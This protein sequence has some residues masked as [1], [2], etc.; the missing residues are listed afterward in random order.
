MSCGITDPLSCVGKLAA[1][2]ATSA[3][4]AVCASFATAADALLKAF[5]RSF[6]A[7]PPVD[8]ASPAVKSV[9][10]ICL[11]IAAGVAAVL[12]LGQVIRTAISRD[13]SPLAEGL[14]GIGKAAIACML[15]LVIT[16]AAVTAAD[17]LTSYIIDRSFGSAAGLTAHLTTVLSFIG[18][19]GHSNAELLGGASLL[20]L[21]ALAG[22]ALVLV[23]WFELL[24]RNAAIAVLVATSPIAAAGLASS[25][26]RS[27]WPRTAWA[28]GQLIAVKPIIALIFA[29]GIGLTGA[30][31]HGIETLLA[32]MLI[33]MLAAVAWPVI[34]RFLTFSTAGASGSAGL[35]VVLGFVAG[36]ISGGGSLPGQGMQGQLGAGGG[37]GAAGT[38]GEAA[39]G[40]GAAAGVAA[41]G[42]AAGVLALAAAGVQAAHRAS[43]ALAG[44]MGDVA[45]NAGLAPP[46]TPHHSFPQG[47]RSQR[48]P[49][50]AGEQQ[51]PSAAPGQPSI[52][53]ADDGWGS[54]GWPEPDADP[55][56]GPDWPGENQATTSQHPGLAS[57]P[58]A[59]PA[60]PDPDPAEEEEGTDGS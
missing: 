8:L 37:E 20:L 6:T 57:Q 19:A 60:V 14:T 36:R 45:G 4:D 33:L 49:R 15:T 42:A 54:S 55:W 26:S 58:P 21:L 7:I 1:G 46:G 24:L 28:T 35:G 9:Y 11:G 39:G 23:L 17:S 12:L 31:S 3:W 56:E 25:A 52:S 32:G 40:A 38:A 53:P 16:S 47:G 27:W 5:A 50:P 18:R 34:A 2:E 22:I 48:S 41:G 30:R 29:T 44:Q 59:A 51:Q 10:A 43:T 13:G